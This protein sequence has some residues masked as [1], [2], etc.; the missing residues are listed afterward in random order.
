MVLGRVER[1]IFW[2]WVSDRLSDLKGFLTLWSVGAFALSGACQCLVFWSL[3]GLGASRVKVLGPF[4]SVKG[5]DLGSILERFGFSSWASH[6]LG[7]W[8]LVEI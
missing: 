6:R 4:G 7:Y 8:F 3:V 1:S 2:S 5:F